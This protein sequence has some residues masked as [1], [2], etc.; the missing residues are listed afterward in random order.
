MIAKCQSEDRIA[1]YILDV[2]EWTL[3]YDNRDHLNYS[4][5]WNKHP[6]RGMSNPI[7]HMK[8]D[9]SFI[10]FVETENLPQQ[11]KIFLIGQI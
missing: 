7:E 1:Y 11:V 2:S 8:T 10:E 5:F 9:P 4:G 3:I 6:Y